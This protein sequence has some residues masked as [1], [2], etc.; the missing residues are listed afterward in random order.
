MKYLYFFTNGYFP[1][2][3]SLFRVFFVYSLKLIDEL[4]FFNFILIFG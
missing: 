2:T 3:K 4:C 1:F